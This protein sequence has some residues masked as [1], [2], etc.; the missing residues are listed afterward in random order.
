[1]KGHK[2]GGVHL[3]CPSTGWS[4]EP[5]PVSG[6]S[7]ADVLLDPDTAHPVLLLSQDQRRVGRQGPSKQILPNNPERFDCRP[8]VLG[9][10]SFSSGRHYWEVEVGNVTV[11][12]VG[13][14][15][16]RVQRKGE[17]LLVPHNGFWA[18][19]L[20]GNQCRVLSSPEKTLPLKERLRRVA[21]LL[22]YECGDVS[23]YNMRDRPHI[24]T[25]PRSHFSGPLRPFLRLGSDDSPLFLCPAFTE[26][27]GVTVPEGGLVLHGAGTHHSHQNQ[28][29]GLRAQ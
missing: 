18:L 3:E 10:Q 28:R 4:P 23:F 13:V 2:D 25:C 14:C 5:C 8:C 6:D 19:E 20:F 21:V 24:Y 27:Q 11:W 1:M 16:D 9:V 12:A 22:D 7:Y 29:P 17:A 15:A 26:A